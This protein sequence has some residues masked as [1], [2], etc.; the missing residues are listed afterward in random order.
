VK[1]D[2]EDSQNMDSPLVEPQHCAIINCMVDLS[3]I[4]RTICHK[5]YLANAG[6]ADMVTLTNQIEK[7]LDGW[8]QGLPKG[9]R[10]PLQQQH[11]Q[12]SLRAAKDAQWVKRQRMVLNIRY[13]NLRILLF[14]ALLLRS[15]PAGRTY[16]AG[17]QENILKCLDSAKLTISIIYQIYE[18]N[19]F[20]QTWYA[21]LLF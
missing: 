20:F 18:H 21:Y 12:G 9:I 10:P 16:I 19:D 3:R 8:R 5:I 4:T 6:V 11:Q 15:P 7:N 1:R 14:G 17:C 2:A 13:H